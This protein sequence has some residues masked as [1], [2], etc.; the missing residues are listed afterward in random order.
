M[1]I[2]HLLLGSSQ[3]F[4]D[5]VA[6]ARGEA[7]HLGFRE[8]WRKVSVMS[9]H[10]RVH[11]G[12]QPGDRVA[13]ALSNCVESIEVMYAIWHAGL[14]AV[15]MNAKL[16]A[17]EF[18]FILANS[19]AR[20]C[21]VTPDLATT[22]A[23]AAREAPDL[24]EIVDVSTRP[25]GFMAVG[26]P[27]PMADRE[28]E[29]AA[30]LFY[31]S[32]TTGRPKG[33]TLTHRNLLVMTLN[34]YADLDRPVAGGSMVHA[35]PIS[36]GSGLWNFPMLARGVAQ[37]FPES[38]KY[39]VPETVALMNRWPDCSIFLAPT[40]VKRLVEHPDVGDLR[41]GALRLVTYG[42]APMYVSDL[43]RALDTLGSVLCQLYG[44]GES[45]MTIT[46][47]SREMHALRDHPRWEARLASAGIAD[48]CVEVRVVDEQGQR[49][50]AGEV[51]EIIAKGDTVMSGYWN[52]PGA[53]ARSLRDGWLWTGDVGSLDE[54][55]FLTLKDRSKD[56]IISGGSNIYPREIEDVLNLHPAVAECSVV[57]RPHPEWG[58]E[59]VAFVVTRPGAVLTSAELDRLC[60]DN[61]ARFKR[62]KDYRFIDAL[63]KN[64]YGKIL[65][66]ELRA[67][68]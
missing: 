32:G 45:P 47:L 38:G 14:C 10:L 18:A 55:G 24:K 37:V 33:A 63:P 57:G 31:T 4:C 16:H 3:E 1:N 20:L 11:F 66:T 56:M 52:D 30:W 54:D 43:K 8:L 26:D 7:P 6:L 23:E 2:A 22:I 29:D 5:H 9:T 15:P 65:K 19:G 46:H 64:N 13:F 61:I 44:Q 49:L 58:E 41:P 48:S 39:D 60:L 27:S 68:L 40:M 12:L 35:A 28:S 53:T 17:R 51:G 36:H 21:F 34:Y 62:P 59:V 50:P 25:Y 67:L 42:G